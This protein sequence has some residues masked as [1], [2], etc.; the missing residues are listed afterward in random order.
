MADNASAARKREQGLEAKIGRIKLQGD[1]ILSLMGVQKIE[2][3][4]VRETNEEFQKQLA[5]M[6]SQN[7]DFKME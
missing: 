3:A 4:T 2:V 1:E 5:T 6:T 7:F